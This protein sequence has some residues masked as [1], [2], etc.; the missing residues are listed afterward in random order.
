MIS[1]V[2]PVWNEKKYLEVCLKS[3]ENQNI[4]ADEI[5]YVIDERTNDGSE[6]VCAEYGYQVIL[7]APGKLTARDVGVKAAKGDIIIACDSDTFY[8]STFIQDVVNMFKDEKVIAVTGITDDL[9]ALVPFHFRWKMLG[10]ASAFRKWVY[11]AVGGFD[12]EIDQSEHGD[13]VQ[14]EEKE[15][16]NRINILGEIKRINTP[17]HSLRGLL[18]HRID[19]SGE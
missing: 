13:M 17:V 4:K 16:Y 15:F 8:P 3:L 1:V 12:L 19:S 9:S 2:L 6:V 7:V 18:K 11:D 5:I 14:E 10:C